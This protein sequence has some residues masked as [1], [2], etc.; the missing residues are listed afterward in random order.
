MVFFC[1]NG[2]TIVLLLIFAL[3]IGG[4]LLAGQAAFNAEQIEH[5]GLRS[6]WPNSCRAAGSSGPLSRTGI[7]NS[8]KWQP[9]SS[10]QPTCSSVVLQS[11][12]IL[13]IQARCE[14]GSG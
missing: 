1:N 11:Y 12:V 8:C 2:L 10:S 3:S 4:M 13:I 14:R 6:L 5:G 7:A 9:M